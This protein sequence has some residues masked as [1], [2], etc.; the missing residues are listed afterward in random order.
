MDNIRKLRR[1][2]RT[3]FLVCMIVMDVSMALLV[4]LLFV[5][6]SWDEIVNQIQ[7]DKELGGILLVLPT[8]VVVCN[9]DIVRRILSWHPS[10]KNLPPEIRAA[11]NEQCMTGMICGNGILCEDGYLLVA[12]RE[13]KVAGPGELAWIDER[14]AL[15]GKAKSLWVMTHRHRWLVISSLGRKLRGNGTFQT[16]DIDTFRRELDKFIS[17]DGGRSDE[18]GKPSEV[19]FRGTNVEVPRTVFQ[20][21]NVE[22]LLEDSEGERNAAGKIQ[23]NS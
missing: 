14:K 13:L 21:T 4:V 7:T 5:F 11:V 10:V 18:T 22:A 12:D 2:T 20:G 15:F 16:V 1:Q 23:K 8:A 3:P 17:G 6:Y 9:I 19:L